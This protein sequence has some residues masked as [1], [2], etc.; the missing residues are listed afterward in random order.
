M[1][2]CNYGLPSLCLALLL[3]LP[4]MAQE[5]RPTPGERPQPKLVRRV[6]AAPRVSVAR[7]PGALRPQ[8]EEDATEEEPLNE[9]AERKPCEIIGAAQNFARPPARMVVPLGTLVVFQTGPDTEGVWYEDA[10]GWLGVYLRVSARRVRTDAWHGIGRAYQA[11]RECGPA[12]GHSDGLQVAWEP[13]RTG[14]YQVRSH[15]V[16]FAQPLRS[17][18]VLRRV[19]ARCR[20]VDVA[21]VMTVVRVVETVTPEDLAWAEGAEPEATFKRVSLEDR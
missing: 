7:L 8:A 19:D 5:E 14:T 12:L 3:G 17:D 21:E 1:K 6:V 16:S 4:A 9:G 18:L 11:K 13:E 2:I 20:D 10:C 15:V